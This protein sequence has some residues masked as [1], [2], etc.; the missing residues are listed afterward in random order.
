MF[1]PGH[2]LGGLWMR[3]GRNLSA[4][5]ISIG[6]LSGVG[7]KKAE[8]DQ[9][10]EESRKIIESK[11]AL[12]E[13]LRKNR[14]TRAEREEWWTAHPEVLASAEPDEEHRPTAPVPSN[15]PPSLLGAGPP[16]EPDP[17]V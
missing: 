8:A 12:R 16:H 9:Q 10:A 6:C 5:A 4:L 14:V 15:L 7:C 13:Q 11:A 17:A 1:D 2:T 3:S